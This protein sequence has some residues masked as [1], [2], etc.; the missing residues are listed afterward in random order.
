MRRPRPL[1]HPFQQ[2]PFSTRSAVAAGVG[3]ARLRSQALAR[4]FHGVRDSA[5]AEMTRWRR[6]RAYQ[7]R[8]PPAQHFSHVT[9][10]LI[11]GFPLPLSF[12]SDTQLHVAAIAGAGFPRARGVVGHQA[13][14]LSTVVMASGCR[15]TSAVDTWCD[16]ATTL[17]LD[18]LVAVGDFLITG[19]E[20]Y[21]GRTP[22]ATLREL[23]AA[24][25]ARNGRRGIRRLAEALEL[26]RYGSLSRMETLTRLLI[27][28]DGLP[29]AELNHTIIDS[30]GR[31]VA[32]VDL[33]FPEWRIAIEYQGDD[34][35]EKGRFRR[36]ITR[37]ER[38]E[39]QGWTVIYVSADDILRT[40]QA[41]LA[42]IRSR[43]LSRG[44]PV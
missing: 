26:V 8:M 14:E 20:P 42:R 16:V 44:A 33:A 40:P 35:R 17:S 22:A 10:A 25:V 31:T 3:E 11:Q 34:H 6:I 12:E 37:R 4:P 27:V 41:T 18:D 24:L 2:H 43:L 29:E 15:V 19:D 30:V 39:D 7:Q 32:M 28:R 21:S 36:D 5:S 1:P 9:A 38:I 23:D 13:G